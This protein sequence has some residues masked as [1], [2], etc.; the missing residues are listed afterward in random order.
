VFVC[1]SA[2]LTV[3][4][5]L[6]LCHFVLPPRHHNSKAKKCSGPTYHWLAF[7]QELVGQSSVAKANDVI[8]FQLYS[9]VTDSTVVDVNTEH[10]ANVMQSKT[11]IGRVVLDNSMNAVCTTALS[12]KKT[13]RKQQEGETI[14]FLKLIH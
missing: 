5:C 9:S 12:T 2:C 14:A 4:H 3:S 8:M 6:V 13:N 11:R 7:Q 10:A 1:L